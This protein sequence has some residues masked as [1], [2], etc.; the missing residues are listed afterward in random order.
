MHVAPN[1]LIE[2]HLEDAAG[3]HLYR[4]RVEDAYEDLLVV[5]AP[6]QRGSL[7]PLRVGTKLK[8]EF[9]LQDGL[10]QGRFKREAVLEK[11]FHSNIPLLQLRLLG[12][13]EKIQ[14][15]NFLRVPVFIDAFFVFERNDGAESPSGSGL[16]LDLSAGGFLFRSSHPFELDDQIRITFRLETEQVVAEAFM[17]R[18]VQTESGVDYG[19]A[20]VDLSEQLRKIIIKFVFKRQISLAELAR[21]N[22]E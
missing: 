9:K 10:E 18:F 11:R 12:S 15:R 22:R 7:V 5:G 17:V 8:V 21:N 16:I 19:F 2:L 6:F 1:Q 13:W 14:E 4:T 20:F 3:S